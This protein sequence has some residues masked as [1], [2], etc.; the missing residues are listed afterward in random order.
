[1]K[2]GNLK[3]ECIKILNIVV[4]HIENNKTDYESTDLK[5]L[6]SEARMYYD[7]YLYKANNEKLKA[8]E[9]EQMIVPKYEEGLRTKLREYLDEA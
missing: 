6:L 5:Y 8:Q 2:K 7:L 9:L 1:M 4:N 3:Q